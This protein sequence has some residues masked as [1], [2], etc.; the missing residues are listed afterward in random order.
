LPKPA[1]EQKSAAAQFEP[2]AKVNV[3]GSGK[4]LKIAAG[5]GVATGIF[6]AGWR[7]MSKRKE[8]KL[9]GITFK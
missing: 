4:G 7:I 1:I 9:S 8:H 5:V 2:S 3:G 6:F